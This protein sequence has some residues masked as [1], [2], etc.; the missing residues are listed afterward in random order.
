[1]STDLVPVA[2][3]S[4]A[5]VTFAGVSGDT[6]PL[7]IDKMELVHGT[8]RVEGGTVGEFYCE[9]N[10]QS[11]K[12]LFTAPLGF[13]TKRVLFPKGEFG[14]EPLCRSN[15][16]KVPA[17]NVIDKKSNSCATC[18][19]GPKLWKDYRKTHIK[20]PCDEKIEYTFVDL[21]TMKVY[22]INV[23]GTSVSEIKGA[24]KQIM[25]DVDSANLIAKFKKAKGEEVA[26]LALDLDSFIVRLK[27]R[28]GVKDGI[29][30]YMIQFEVSRAPEADIQAF[31]PIY[32]DIR[33][34][35]DALRSRGHEADEVNEAE[36]AINNAMDPQAVS[37]VTGEPQ[38][39]P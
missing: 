28:K 34:R 20:P 39:E 21:M 7:V 25:K 33:E 9:S 2:P 23:G 8:S 24:M 30:F 37:G 27:P 26:E 5:L 19:F 32:Q 22:R 10:K 13:Q 31:R 4:N 18:D 29:T 17:P 14:A 6:L 38:I 3:Q 36:G 35:F 1:M 12:E 11:F 16:G 15:D